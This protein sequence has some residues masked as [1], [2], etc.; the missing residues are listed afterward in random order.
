MINEKENNAAETPEVSSLKELF[1]RQLN[2]RSIALT[3]IFILAV[4]YTFYFARALFIPLFFAL[5]F[6][7]MLSPAV[8]TLRKV[9]IPPA[10]GAAIVLSLLLAIFTVSRANTLASF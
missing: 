9:H 4:M 2:I 5:L 6:N 1:N 8:D 7:L 10:F 3:G